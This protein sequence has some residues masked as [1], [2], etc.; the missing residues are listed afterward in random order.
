MQKIIGTVNGWILLGLYHTVQALE[1]VFMAV[2]QLFGMFSPKRLE[3]GDIV[4]YFHTGEM[5]TL[6]K[7]IALLT[8][9]LG[10]LLVE[11]IFRAKTKLHDVITNLEPV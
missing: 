10:Y 7:T 3:N 9:G 1:S 8:I 5:G 2:L 11:N 4:D 6:Y